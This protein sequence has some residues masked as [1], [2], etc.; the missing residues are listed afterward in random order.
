MRL[1]PLTYGLGAL[2]ACLYLGR[3]VA[4]ADVPALVPSLGVSALFGVIAWTAATA[5]AERSQSL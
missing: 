1:D 4:F 5:V 3:G 2:R